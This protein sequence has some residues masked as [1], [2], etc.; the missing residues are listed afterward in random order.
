MNIQAEKLKLMKL[1]LETDNPKVLESIKKLFRN[2]SKA[3]FWESLSDEQK[4]E[5]ELGIQEVNEG[6]TV[7][8][9]KFIR[10]H[11]K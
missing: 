6:K 1:I 3:D 10:K 4:Q 5:I 2:E 9:E 8:Y 7:D 11:R